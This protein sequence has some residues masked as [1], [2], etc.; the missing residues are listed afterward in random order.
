M[1]ILFTGGG[2]AGHINPAVAL[3][4]YF[5]KT[6]PDSEILYVGATGGME[7]RLVPEEGINFKGI[8][9][10]GFSRKLNIEG[11]KKNLQTLKNIIIASKE[12]KKI[13]KEFKP[14][15]CIGT[16]GYVCGPLLR[17]AGKMKIPFIIHDSNS[18]PG[19]TTKLLARKAS[20]VLVINEE[21]KKH[22][23]KNLKNIEITGT[24]VRENIAVCDKAEAKQKLGIDNDY[25]VILSFGGSLGAKAI[26]DVMAKFIIKHKNDDINFIHGFGKR[27]HFVEDELTKNGIDLKNPKYNIKEYIKNM[28][29]CLAAA[30]LVI[31]RAGAT[32]LS[33]I[34]IA[35]KPAILIPSPN[36][37]ENHQYYNAMALVNENAASI[38][39]EKNFS[40]ETL[41]KE[42]S[43]ILEN[44][45]K[46]A[47]DYAK[48]LGR[49]AI[50][51]SCERIYEISKKVINKREKR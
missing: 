19:V 29:E 5:K 27:G 22:L 47:N 32:T 37:A 38:I 3:A 36:V 33:E 17:T 40:F 6:E 45:K 25:P 2:T 31:C 20:K 39:E 18:F 51:G 15:I 28:A 9:I 49:I 8:T 34:Q 50:T 11:F 41:E 4:H 30:D 7:S 26:N 16:G 13:L 48:N 21:A 1:K 44:N 43:K 10:S 12:S 23:P 46:I 14:D 24:P 42:V 35:K